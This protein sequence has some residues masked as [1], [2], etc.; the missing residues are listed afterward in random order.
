MEE[1][2]QRLDHKA[3]E[4][5]RTIIGKLNVSFY[6]PEAWIRVYREGADVSSVSIP[7]G[8]NTFVVITCEW[9]DTLKDYIDIY[10]LQVSIEDKP[11]DIS[12]TPHEDGPSGWAF[13]H[14]S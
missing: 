11:R 2:S 5:L 12:G 6:F 4:A 8:Q 9:A 14:A 1:L 10:Y 3:E 7:T 13:S